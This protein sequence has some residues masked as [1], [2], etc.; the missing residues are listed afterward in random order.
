MREIFQSSNVYYALLKHVS[1]LIHLFLLATF[2]AF[3]MVVSILGFV[4]RVQCKAE[5]S[6]HRGSLLPSPVLVNTTFSLNELS[7]ADMI[8]SF[9]PLEPEG[10]AFG[11]KHY[12]EHMKR[13]L[14][15]CRANNLLL[16]EYGRAQLVCAT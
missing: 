14:P 2:H 10:D 5:K 13:T 15:L 8:F 3:G 6:L 12:S 7:R 1:R 16:A 4:A 11:C 9:L